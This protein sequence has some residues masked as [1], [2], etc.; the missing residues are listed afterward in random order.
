MWYQFASRRHRHAMI[1][2]RKTV[3]RSALAD[4]RTPREPR[5][6]RGDEARAGPRGMRGRTRPDRPEEDA[7]GEIGRERDAGSQQPDCGTAASAEAIERG[8]GVR[9]LRPVG[10]VAPCRNVSRPGNASTRQTRPP[11]IEEEWPGK[12]KFAD[13]RSIVALCVQRGVAL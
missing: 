7:H 2:Q 8:T 11:H 9:C 4:Q 6:L 10:R 13:P 12:R 3:A 1:S 5:L